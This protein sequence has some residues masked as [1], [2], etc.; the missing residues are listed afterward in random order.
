V[1]GDLPDVNLLLS[2]AW[3]N[4]QFH[5]PARRWFGD[6]SGTW[7]TCPLT[8]LGFV[9]LSSNPAFTPHAKTPLEATSLLAA[10][11]AHPQHRLLPDS[12][13]V[14]GQVFRSLASRLE[15]HMQVTDAYLIALA[16]S[17]AVRLV[18]FDRRIEAIC[19]AAGTVLV[20]DA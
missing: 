15:G 6:R 19:P 20:L 14:A 11:T 1:S 12:E 16:M 10:M 13:A 4:H 18:T 8:Q 9:R 2:L 7:M 3:P 17:N 5:G